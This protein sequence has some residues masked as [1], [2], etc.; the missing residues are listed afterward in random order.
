[1]KKSLGV[2]YIEIIITL[3]ILAVVL[4]PMVQTYRSLVKLS[5]E[6]ILRITAIFRV[7]NIL[8]EEKQK[9]QSGSTTIEDDQVVYTI[10]RTGDDVS[11]EATIGQESVFK[12]VGL[13]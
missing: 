3:F 9:S 12:L 13:R 5:E 11:V 8:S 6:N 10:I 1:M 4:G 7:Q 2:S